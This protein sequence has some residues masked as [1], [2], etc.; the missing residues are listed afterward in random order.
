M[1][2]M[3]CILFATMIATF[4]HVSIEVFAQLGANSAC[5]RIRFVT[6]QAWGAVEPTA[7]VYQA[8]QAASRVFVHQAW[9][10]QTCNDVDSCI[11][12][13]RSIQAYNQQQKGWPDIG[14]NFLIAGNGGV[15]EG[16]GWMK[17]GFHTLNYN[18]E[19]LGVAFIGTFHDSAPNARME[20][21]FRDLIECS[22]ARGYLVANHAI[23]GHRDARCTIC[24]GDA[25][26]ARLRTF[27][28]FQP[29]PLPRYSCPSSGLTSGALNQHQA[30]PIAIF[31]NISSSALHNNHRS[32]IIFNVTASIAPKQ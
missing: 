5:D 19:S 31:G 16:L 22:V 9:D 15:F 12:R 29:G 11:V 24:P 21:A 18:D 14:Y 17:Q 7:A 30:A 3:I 10:G 2:S 8:R 28:R 23:H 27:P 4:L 6:R 32:Q 25:L 20:Q 26:Y 1:R 13:V